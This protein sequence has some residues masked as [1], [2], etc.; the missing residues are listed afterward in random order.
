MNDGDAWDT[1]KTVALES[2]HIVEAA[3]MREMARFLSSLAVL[4]AVCVG[5]TLSAIAA[6]WSKAETFAVDLV[7]Y[8]FVPDHVVFRRGTVYRLHL[9]NKGR[10]LHEFTAPEF[11]KAIEIGNPEVVGTYGTEIVMQPA[12]KKD[13]FFITRQPGTYKLICSDHDWEGMVGEIVVE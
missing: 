6:D 5:N 12:D 3:P 1:F 4:A 8:R 2:I 10:E 9:E 11:L 7:D 13:L